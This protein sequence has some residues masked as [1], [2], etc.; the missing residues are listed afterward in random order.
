M[1]WCRRVDLPVEESPMMISL[2]RKSGKGEGER[3]E[4]VRGNDA[5]GKD[6]IGD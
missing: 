2:K 5:I 3:S 6:S 1:N 4:V